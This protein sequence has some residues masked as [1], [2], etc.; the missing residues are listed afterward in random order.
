MIDIKPFP[1]CGSDEVEYKPTHFGDGESH[2]VM[3]CLE[4][5]CT[6]PTSEFGKHVKEP[7][8]EWNRRADE[9][10]R[11]E[12]IKVADEIDADAEKIAGYLGSC[13]GNFSKSDAD[14]YYKFAGWVCRIGKA[15]GVE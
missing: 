1:F 3:R 6:V 5:G 12:L 8:S 9:C 11:D 15:L 2:G 4:C 7:Y 13:D 10:D 14:E